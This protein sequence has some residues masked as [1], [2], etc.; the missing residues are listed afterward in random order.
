M[1]FSMDELNTNN[2]KNGSPSYTLFTYHVTAHEDSTHFELYTSQNKK[3]KKG[4]LISLALKMTH[5]KNIITDGLATTMCFI[6]D[7]ISSH[8]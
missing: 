6:F 1:V 4:E 2:L 7:E 3:I 5:K 8:T